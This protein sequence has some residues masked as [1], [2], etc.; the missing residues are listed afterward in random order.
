MDASTQQVDSNQSSRRGSR[1]HT[2]ISEEKM[3]MM[4]V[5]ED[6]AAVTRV[7]RSHRHV[8]HVPENLQ[9]TSSGSSNMLRLRFSFNGVDNKVDITNRKDRSSSRNNSQSI[10]DH[11]SSDEEAEHE[12]LVIRFPSR[13][14]NTRNSKRLTI[15]SKSAGKVSTRRKK[16]RVNYAEVNSDED[17]N[18]EEEEEEQVEETPRRPNHRRTQSANLAVADNSNTSTS[19]DSQEGSPAEEQDGSSSDSDESKEEEE[20][21]VVASNRQESRSRKATRTPPS[22]NSNEDEDEAP[23]PGKRVYIMNIAVIK[24]LK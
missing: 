24:Q 4:D 10:E 12:R 18:D 16:S 6:D 5:I 19:D 21:V 20:E 3:E 15:S 13:S 22:D 2:K 17:I 23:R 11:Q 14:H 1:R 8:D 7:T 9:R